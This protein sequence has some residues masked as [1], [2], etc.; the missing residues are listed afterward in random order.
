MLSASP[1]PAFGVS[2]GLRARWRVCAGMRVRL[3]AR[4]RV[5][6][7]I[8]MSARSPVISGV[9]TAFRVASRV[10][11]RRNTNVHMFL[12]PIGT[13]TG[14]QPSGPMRRRSPVFPDVLSG[15]PQFLVLFDLFQIIIP[16]FIVLCTQGG[17]RGEYFSWWPLFYAFSQGI[18][19]T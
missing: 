13:S 6:A 18:P 11:V 5:C 10:F 16:I 2:G 12:E 9:F 1:L 19:R 14:E 17:F 7:S 3:C 8:A 4:W 15:C